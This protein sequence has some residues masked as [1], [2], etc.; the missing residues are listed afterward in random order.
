LITGALDFEI[1]M[2]PSYV[3]MLSPDDTSESVTFFHAL[4]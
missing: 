4:S 2:S 1:M 3:I